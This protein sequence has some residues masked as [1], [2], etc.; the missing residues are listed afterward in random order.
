M[1]L[2]AQVNAGQKR[3]VVV[4][5]IPCSPLY[6]WERK[7]YKAEQGTLKHKTVHA[8]RSLQDSDALQHA[9]PTDVTKVT[10][11][12]TQLTPEAMWI[13]DQSWNAAVYCCL[14]QC[15]QVLQ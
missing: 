1:P 5:L 15:E 12:S 10:R 2:A 13:R 14:A 7:M 3:N 11:A 6:S 4:S 9:E 8:K